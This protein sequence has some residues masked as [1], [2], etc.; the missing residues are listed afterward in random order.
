MARLG[1]KKGQNR[2]SS[3]IARTAH[4]LKNNVAR[5]PKRGG[6][7]TKAV[8]GITPDVYD[9]QPTKNRRSNVSLAL[10]ED[11]LRGGRYE[12][13]DEEEEE[14]GSSRR[15]PRLIGEGADDE[16]IDSDEDDEIDSDVAFG[17]SDE[18]QFAGSNFDK[19]AQPKAKRTKF[20]KQ[21]SVRFA[22]VDLDE[23]DAQDGAMSDVAPRASE[24]ESEEEEEE[25]EDGEFFDVL[26]ILDGRAEPDLEGDNELVKST[27]HLP[28]LVH[29]SNDARMANSDEDEDVEEDG[30]ETG[31]EEEDEAEEN[32]SISGS[33][34]DEADDSALVAL[35][36]LV[37]GLESGI[38]RKAEDD[39]EDAN[40]DAAAKQM[41]KKKRLLK[42]RTESGF[43][44][45]FGAGAAGSSKLSLDDLLTPLASRQGALASLKKSMKPLASSSDPKN[46]PLPAPLPIRTQER[47][48]RE[49]A[50]EQT[51]QEV[52][53]WTDTMKRIQE[54]EHLSFPL[55]GPRL[56]KTSN[57]ELTAK[58]KPTTELESSIDRLLRSAK[59]REEDINKTEDLMM[60]NLSV[61]EVA[62]RRAELR[63]MRELAF[64][65]D[66]KAKRVAKIKSKAYRRIHK[67][68]RAKL[69]AKLDASAVQDDGDAEE[70]RLK[71]ETERARERATLKHKN[72]G[73]WAKA[74]KARGELD[75]DQRRDINEML[76]KGER[77]RRRIQGIE[78]DAEDG[79]SS[80]SSEMEGDDGVLRIKANAFEELR[81]IREKKDDENEGADEKQQAKNVFQ[82]KF[83]K[84]AAARKNAEIERDIDDFR[85]QMGDLPVDSDNEEGDDV[86]D[87]ENPAPVE[88]VNGRMVFRPTPQTQ[89]SLMLPPP[90]SAI[91]ETSTLRSHDSITHSPV[92]TINEDRHSVP[93]PASTSVA[94]TPA[95]ELPNPWLSES[96]STL[97]VAKRKNELIVGKNVTRAQKSEASTMKQLKKSTEERQLVQDDAVVEIVVDD[98][99]MLKNT[100]NSGNAAK[101]VA[102]NVTSEG[103]KKDKKEKKKKKDKGKAKAVQGPEEED[104]EANSEVEE[105]EAA[106]KKGSKVAAFE[107]RELVARAFAGDNVVR[108][109][110]EEKRRETEA[111]APQEVDTTLAGWG[112]WGGAGLKKTAPK[113]HLIKKVAGID[114]KSRAD[115]GKA[116]VIISER[117]DKKA[118]KFAVKD[119]PYPYT[120][121][122][123]FEAR[124]S[125]PLGAEWNTRLGF[126]RGTLPRVVKKM[127]TIIDP[128][129]K[130]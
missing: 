126:Q 91:S 12:D 50:Y 100:E 84:D 22:E 59:L 8:N 118:L 113:P 102:S 10:D 90:P 104:S 98:A 79:S 16:R 62:E 129:E 32:A 115:Y 55:Q 112:S 108:E 81:E 68:E 24:G 57:L 31:E 63:K 120:S 82:M 110:E 94:P 56:V 125:T 4:G 51:K 85:R 103:K 74:M 45:E 78:S 72:T 25:E 39:T 7:P 43:E 41:K 117:R 34:E 86:D 89:P 109:F 21:R 28:S 61:E 65:A 5:F 47:L 60:K 106:L 119:L 38:K 46:Q 58:F 54:A 27:E 3:S 122:A 26:D 14:D 96:P 49:A 107:Q 66:A 48:D 88:R 20:N 44:T 75:E 116:H 36:K 13:D 33:D 67:K 130:L 19:K 73:K 101:A 87:P 123:Q 11:E 9:Y 29:D 15:R 35:G 97:K 83:M 99:L 42:D 30:E 95:S 37:S 92:L 1:Q 64:R 40:E 6:R 93:P 121:K 2:S 52:D 114:P 128:L 111:D 53:K 127:G 80:D 17:G 18:E 71:A 23:G 69:L 70:A 105:Q 76:E 124:M 77:L